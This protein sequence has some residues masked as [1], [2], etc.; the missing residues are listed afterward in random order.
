[1]PAIT[2]QLR[3]SAGT[4]NKGEK[5]YGQIVK[6]SVLIGGSSVLNIAFGIVRTKVMAV[7]LGP[8]GYGLLGIYDSICSLTR[9][10]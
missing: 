2:A 7:L 5:S 1:M 10:V 6:S 8:S 9:T 4:L 3:T